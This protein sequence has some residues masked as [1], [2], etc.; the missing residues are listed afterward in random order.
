MTAVTVTLGTRPDLDAEERRARAMRARD[1]LANAG[2][3]FDEVI[4]DLTRDLLGTT[5]GQSEIRES[6]YYQIDAAA[7]VKGHLSRILE[8]QAAEEKVNERKHRN[9][10][11]ADAE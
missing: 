8:Q 6:L 2:W 4:S 10:P 11:P 5:P 9:E 1:V 7:Q 3:V